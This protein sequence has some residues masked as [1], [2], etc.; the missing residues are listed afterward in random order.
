M[1]ERREFL[2]LS[3]LTLAVVFTGGGFDV[4]KASQLRQRPLV[5]ISL[6]KDNY[7]TFY[8]NKSEMGQ[9]VHTGLAMVVADEL[10]FPWERVKVA[11]APVRSEYADPLFGIHLT[12]GST[13]VRNMYGVLRLAGATMKRLLILSASQRLKLPVES[14][15][16]RMGYLLYPGGRIAY[17]DLAEDAVKL[18]LPKDVPLKKESEFVYIGKGVPRVDT[19]DKVNGRALFGIDV[20]LEGMVYATVIRPPSYSSKLLRVD[21]SQA[22]KIKGYIRAIPMGE[23]VGIVAQDMFSLLKAKESI[24]VEWSGG[25]SLD[26]RALK[27]LF[28]ESLKKPGEVVYKVGNAPQYISQ[29]SLKTSSVYVLPY[30][31]HAHLEPLS[32]VVDVKKDRCLIYAPVQAQ[33]SVLRTAEEITGLDEGRI[34]VRTTYLGGGFG[35]KA[36]TEFVKEALLM[37]KELKRPVKLIY[38]REEDVKYAH[39]RPMSATLMEGAVDREGNILAVRHKIAIHPISRGS[40]LEGIENTLYRFPNFTVEY[41]PVKLDFPVW[42]WRSVGHSHNAF[43]METFI[44]E[45]AS[46]AKKDPVA[47]RLNLLRDERAKKVVQVCAERAGWGRPKRGHAMGFA[48]HYSFGSHCAHAVEVSLDTKSGQ[49]RV[50]RVVCVMDIGPV[51]VHPDLARQQVEGAIIMGLSSALKERVSFKNGGPSSL[52]FDTYPILRLDEAPEEI[53]VYFLKGKGP[54]GGVGEPPLPPIAPAVA[55]ALFWGYGIKVRELPMTPERIKHL[56]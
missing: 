33:T 4:V 43:V 36:S 15:Q 11:P 29:A 21:D 55:N 25:I 23:K 47:L 10:D 44:D 46:L 13:S 35:R 22:K 42:Y 32:C 12:G 34:E 27:K 41:V 28:L 51:L 30:L 5:W 31:Y 50:H 16:A 37:S 38:T 8:S 1:M 49:L 2:K 6:S 7:L 20:K 39:F 9:G 17:G 19:E 18:P 52:N 26:D 54:M 48:Y 53:E 3:G 56:L 40:S 45:L 24:K 14:I